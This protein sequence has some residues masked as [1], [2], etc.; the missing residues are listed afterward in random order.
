MSDPMDDRPP[1]E[2]RP[3]RD[4]DLPGLLAT[5]IVHVSAL[6]LVYKRLERR[7]EK[8]EAHKS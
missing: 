3:P 4:Q 2:R 1:D 6:R 5:L 8:L 7:V